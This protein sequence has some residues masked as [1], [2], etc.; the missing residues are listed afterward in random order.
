MKGLLR[1]LLA[2]DDEA[3]PVAADEPGEFAAAAP[4]PPRRHAVTVDRHTRTFWARGEAAAT[5]VVKADAEL[6]GLGAAR[7]PGGVEQHPPSRPRGNPAFSETLFIELMRAGRFAR[8]Y[9]QLSPECQRLWGSVEQ[10][11]AAH[12]GGAMRA[13]QGV[14]VRA[15]RYLDGWTDPDTGVTH[16]HVAELEVEYAL[17]SADDPTRIQRTVHLV[18]VAGRWR[19]VCAPPSA[20]PGRPTV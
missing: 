13:V 3:S 14:S 6:P 11:T 20:P 17:G 9:D 8:A 5:T 15:V 1:R 10:F 18:P 16:C 2:R 19:S 12:G 7:S 4:S